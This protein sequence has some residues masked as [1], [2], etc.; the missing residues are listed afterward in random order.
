VVAVFVVHGELA[1]TL[2]A[3]LARAAAADPGQDLERLLAVGACALLLRFPRLGDEVVE[4]GHDPT[5]GQAVHALPCDAV[6]AG[7]AKCG[8]SSARVPS[9]TPEPR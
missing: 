5:I 7:A 3:E 2:A 8:T 6:G 4:L 1:Q 9:L